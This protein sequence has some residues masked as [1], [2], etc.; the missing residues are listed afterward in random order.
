MLCLEVKD[1]DPN[2]RAEVRLLLI[3]LNVFEIFRESVGD[4]NCPVFVNS[5]RVAEGGGFT[6]CKSH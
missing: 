4:I 1:L 2:E 6:V 3:V 5:K